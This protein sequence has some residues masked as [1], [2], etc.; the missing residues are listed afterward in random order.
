MRLCPSSLTALAF[1]RDVPETM[2]LTPDPHPGDTSL[3][4]TVETSDGRQ[5]TTVQLHLNVLQAFT[6]DMLKT[7]CIFPP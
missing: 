5:I 7:K 1:P 2:L 6:T 4:T 3:P